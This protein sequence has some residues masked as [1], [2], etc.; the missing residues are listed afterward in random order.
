[1]ERVTV[2]VKASSTMDAFWKTGAHDAGYDGCGA[3]THKG[4]LI[5]SEESNVQNMFKYLNTAPVSFLANTCV[6]VRASF[7]DVN[8]EYDKPLYFIQVRSG[9]KAVYRTLVGGDCKEAVAQAGDVLEK[10][11]EL[12]KERG[13]A[14][15][16]PEVEYNPD[17]LEN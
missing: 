4:A 8:P 9:V 3:H 12:A 11:R 17:W 1:M 7:L 5:C 16:R 14:M 6:E 2:K 15:L 10:I 13:I